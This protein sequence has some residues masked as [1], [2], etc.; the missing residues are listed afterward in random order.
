M[1]DPI[2]ISVDAVAHGNIARLPLVVLAG[3]IT[4][5]GP[6]VAPRYIALAGVLS[7]PRRAATIGLFVAGMLLSYAALGFGAGVLQLL[8]GYAAAIYLALAI[9][10][11]GAGIATLIRE[12]RC[13]HAC[14]EHA[15]HARRASA[16]FTL[17]AASALVVSPCC[18]PVVAAVIG[19]SAFDASPLSRALL[20]GAFALGHAAPLFF[21]GAGGSLITARLRRWSAGPAPAVISGTLMLALGLYYGLLV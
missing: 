8:A 6:C 15:G 14:G 13:E 19:L 18:T 5:V 16:V 20:L 2:A 12:P 10:L 21:L 17:G 9:V 1:I 3:A 11:G 7:G 4:S